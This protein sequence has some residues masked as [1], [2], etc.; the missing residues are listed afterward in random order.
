[1]TTNA[2]N[3]EIVGEEAPEHWLSSRNVLI[4]IKFRLPWSEDKTV[5]GRVHA[6]AGARLARALQVRPHLHQCEDPEVPH[7][8]YRC[9]Q[10]Y[11]AFTNTYVDIIGEGKMSL[12]SDIWHVPGVQNRAG[13]RVL[14]WV[15]YSWDEPERGAAA[16]EGGAQGEERKLLPSGTSLWIKI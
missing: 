1:M 6:R 4:L 5:R 11:I 7:Q 14:H 15:L 2:R 9:T 8:Q 13:Q 12:S 16:G 10:K 3:Q